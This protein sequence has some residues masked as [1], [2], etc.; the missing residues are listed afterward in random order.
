[1]RARPSVPRAL[2]TI[3]GWCPRRS[4]SRRA[5]RCA[6]LGERSA[7][8]PLGQFWHHACHCHPHK[9]APPPT[10][11]P[12]PPAAAAATA[13]ATTSRRC[14][15]WRSWNP[16]P[17][18][19]WR[20]MRATA[21]PMPASR[22]RS[23][24]ACGT[25]LRAAQ[26]MARHAPRATPASSRLCSA[27]RLLAPARRSCLCIKSHNLC[28]PHSLPWVKQPALNFPLLLQLPRSPAPAQP[29]RVFPS[30]GNLLARSA[31]YSPSNPQL[32]AACV[33]YRQ[34]AP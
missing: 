22:P 5:A 1:M 25:R 7:C 29:L 14:P 6:V 8:S 20:W 30:S 23:E 13:R 11:T 17:F 27:H 15:Q 16:A 19:W 3:A 28:C 10:P 32:Y 9:N 26:P 24:P 34:G 31:L 18:T 4:R 21:A 2:A 33:Q 12:H